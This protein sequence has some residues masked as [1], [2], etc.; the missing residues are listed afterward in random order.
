MKA[1]TLKAPWAFAVVALGKRVENR[2]WKPPAALIGQRVAIHAGV[3]WTNHDA[4]EAADAAYDSGVSYPT[5][6]TATV[7]S[8]FKS[9]CVVA[10]ATLARVRH[11]DEVPA[12]ERTPWHLGPWCWE[13]EDVQRVTPAVPA[14]GRLGLWDV[15]LGAETGRP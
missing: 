6:F 10:T 1:L 4:R 15:E 14:K 3:T 9:G 12:E 8:G 11:L 7:K 13:L 2:S 5:A